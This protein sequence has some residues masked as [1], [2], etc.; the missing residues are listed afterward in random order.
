MTNDE[1]LVTAQDLERRG[2]LRRGTAYRMAEAGKLPHY[3]IGCRGR[4][5]RF[6]IDEVVAALRVPISQGMSK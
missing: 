3:I 4:G 2:I 6:R 1:S 5:V